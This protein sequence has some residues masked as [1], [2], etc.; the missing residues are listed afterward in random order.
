[1]LPLLG[2]T[3]G[4]WKEYKIGRKSNQNHSWYTLGARMI[5]E[6]LVPKPKASH[7]L[8]LYF[9]GHVGGNMG[10]RDLTCFHH[11]TLLLSVACFQAFPHLASISIPCL[12]CS[13]MDVL[14]LSQ[15]VVVALTSFPTE[16]NLLLPP[17]LMPI[18]LQSS[19]EILNS[20]YRVKQFKQFLCKQIPQNHGGSIY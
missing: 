17:Y 20:T 13:Q 10:N 15:Y 7:L 1:M 8:L 9:W 5:W 18:H 2:S 3:K 14:T 4:S 16:Y 6:E 19:R 11:I 12:Q